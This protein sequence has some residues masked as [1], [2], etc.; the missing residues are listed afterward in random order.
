M[1]TLDRNG[2]I[3]HVLHTLHVGAFQGAAFGEKDNE[4]TT[5]LSGERNFQG[6]N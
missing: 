4:E 2:Y 6:V 1:F 5:K 3:D